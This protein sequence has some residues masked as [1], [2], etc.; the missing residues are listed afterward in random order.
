MKRKIYPL[1]VVLL[2]FFLVFSACQKDEGAEEPARS[3]SSINTKILRIADNQNGGLNIFVSVTDQDGRAIEGLN[4]SNFEISMIEG[5]KETPVKINGPTLLPSV[6]ITA[7]TMDYSGSMYADTVSIAAMETALGTFI[8]MKNSYDQIELIKFSDSVQV[9]VPLTSSTPSLLA[10]IIDTTFVGH[11]YTAFYRAVIQGINDVQSLA[12]SNPTYLP[13]V[14]G[15]TDGWNNLVPLTM[16]TLL[17]NSI[18]N[19][20][21][22]YTVAYG[23]NPDTTS[24][25]AIADSTGGAYAYNPSATS[26]SILYQIVNGQLSNSVIIPIPPPPAKGKVTYRVTAKYLTNGGLFKDTDEKYFYY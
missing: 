14:I 26:L 8:N 9:T 17:L 19:Q 2:S 21:P 7:L 16:D 4:A 3:V 23:A 20:I 13:S 10:G 1:L 18:N 11:G 12:A 22:V 5:N 6:I 24:L 15:F 25:H